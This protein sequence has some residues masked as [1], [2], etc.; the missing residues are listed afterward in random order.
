MNEEE[1]LKKINI[2]ELDD[3]MLD[4]V[5][6]G[7]SVKKSEDGYTLYDKDGNILAFFSSLKELESFTSKLVQVVGKRCTH[8]LSWY[9][10]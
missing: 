8:G 9:I 4:A 10:S 5:S 6:G 7:L 1:N 3:D 2:T